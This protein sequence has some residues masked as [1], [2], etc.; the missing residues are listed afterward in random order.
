MPRNRLHHLAGCSLRHLQAFSGPPAQPPSSSRIITPPFLTFSSLNTHFYR[1]NV[2]FY[3]WLNYW[4]LCS[5]ASICEA[6]SSNLRQEMQNRPSWRPSHILSQARPGHLSDEL[7]A[8]LMGRAQHVIICR[9]SEKCSPSRSHT[10]K[11]A[12]LTMINFNHRD[13]NRMSE[14]TSAKVATSSFQ[15]DLKC[16]ASI[17]FHIFCNQPSIFYV[18]ILLF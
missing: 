6:V 4:F 2:D 17:S 3:T 15:K 16:T 8:A 5:E 10:V 11:R 14:H 1:F 9:T 18:L 12:P 7:L 13:L